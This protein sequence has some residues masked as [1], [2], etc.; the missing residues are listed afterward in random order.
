MPPPPEGFTLA[1]TLITLGII[2]VVAAMTIPT[3]VGNYQKKVSA[4]KLKK[5]YSNYAQALLFSETE[6]GDISTWNHIEAGSFQDSTRNIPFFTEHL[7]KYMNPAAICDMSMSGRKCSAKISQLENTRMRVLFQDGSCMGIHVTGN[8]ADAGIGVPGVSFSVL[9]DINCN[10][11]PNKIGRDQFFFFGKWSIDKND[12]INYYPLAPFGDG[13]I[14][15]KYKN[16]TRDDLK[17][18]CNKSNKTGCAALI[19]YDNWEI[20]DDYPW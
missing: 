20:K 15:K 11:G 19:K 14:V 6:H 1:E 5:F 10:S 16:C 18:V 12:D 17:K 9:Y 8:S 13:T 4:V 7:Y 2:G 3:L